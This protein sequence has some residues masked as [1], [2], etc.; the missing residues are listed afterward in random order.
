MN[1][2]RFEECRARWIANVEKAKRSLGIALLAKSGRTG[3]SG[4]KDVARA[5]REL[6]EIREALDDT[7][8]ILL[9]LQ[10]LEREE[11]IAI[12]SDPMAWL[13]RIQARINGLR[14]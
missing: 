6:A 1:R 9:A 5:R 13:R 14:Q 10:G 8:A 3:L 2:Q 12:A 4:V 11:H 7:E